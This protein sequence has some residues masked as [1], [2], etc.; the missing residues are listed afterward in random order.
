MYCYEKSRTEDKTHSR[1][2]FSLSTKT[3]PAAVSY[4]PLPDVAQRRLVGWDSEE[5]TDSP[6]SRTGS[7]SEYNMNDIRIHYSPSEPAPGG[8][9]VNGS[10]RLGREAIDMEGKGSDLSGTVQL[11]A[12]PK[13]GQPCVQFMLNKHLENE[14]VNKLEKTKPYLEPDPVQ[15]GKLIIQWL[16]EAKCNSW[17]WED[18]V[19]IA[20]RCE[21]VVIPEKQDEQNVKDDL[22]GIPLLTNMGINDP[23]IQASFQRAKD[24][25]G[26]EEKDAKRALSLRGIIRKV[27]VD[28]DK[29]IELYHKTMPGQDVGIKNKAQSGGQ[30]GIVVTYFYVQEAGVFYLVAYGTHDENNSQAYKIIQ[31]IPKYEHLSR[32]EATYIK[33]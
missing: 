26:L 11:C 9:H 32:A 7:L 20:L 27:Q 2:S 17:E 10:S 21:L 4:Q 16:K 19:R 25:L 15:L 18:I 22:P 23:K 28:R 12:E 3:T 29:D 14:V 13:T 5:L 31:A 24:E 6:Q 8:I 30:G 33:P 1:K